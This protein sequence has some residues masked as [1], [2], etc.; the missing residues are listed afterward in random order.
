MTIPSDGGETMVAEV[1]RR[2]SRCPVENLYFNPSKQYITTAL[3]SFVGT[4]V[5]HI[6]D[7]PFR[8]TLNEGRSLNS[9]DTRDL[10]LA[11]TKLGNA[12]RRPESELRRHLADGD[13]T[14][15]TENRSTKA[16]V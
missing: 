3:Y 7:C 15:D 13:G 6:N 11:A 16:G 1:W 12:Q 9:G 5:N 2:S 4:L 10:A 8:E 14:G